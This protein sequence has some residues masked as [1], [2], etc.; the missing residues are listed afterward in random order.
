MPAQAIFYTLLGL[1]LGILVTICIVHYK[2]KKSVSQLEAQAK[3]VLQKAQAEEKKILSEAEQ[4]SKRLLDSIS[5]EEQERKKRLQE[6]EQKQQKREKEIEQKSAA[7]HQ[8][9]REISQ[10]LERIRQETDK[11][12]LKQRE[13]EA[14]LQQISSLSPNEAR[15]LLLKKVEQE[16]E[17]DLAHHLE[18]I[19]QQTKETAA[20]QVKNILAEAMQ[21]YYGESIAESTIT[22]VPLP[23]DEMKGRIIGREGRNINAFEKLSGVDLIVD[24]TPGAVILSGF[25]LIRRYI[26]KLALERLVADG[27]IHPT[28][29]E[30][31]ITKAKEDVAKMIKEF[32]EK[33]VYELGITGL[34]NEIVKLLGR[35]RFR[36]AYGQNIL[37]HSVEVA[38][39]AAAIATEFGANA[40][41]AKRAGLLHDIGKA[42][43]QEIDGDHCEIGQEIAKKYHLSAEIISAIASH[44]GTVPF[45]S[46]EGIIVYIA[47]LLSHQRQGSQRENLEQHIQ[48]MSNLEQTAL[49]FSGVEQAFAIQAG[50]ELRI[51]VNPSI[52]SDTEAYRLA[53]D[54]AK[55]AEKSSG[56]TGEIKV[57][58]VRETRIIEYAR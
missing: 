3:D 29:I 45:T 27:R 26:A 16:H 11:L 22:T 7:L 31:S 9:E 37:K 43:D 55:A 15:E 47:N 24:E 42:L 41:I 14:M 46:I 51:I 56:F 17:E 23:N 30:E 32:G 53:H 39:L 18:K 40:D 13:A 33:V 12:S 34:P 28:K 50:K 48:R 35:L 44:H 19:I 5:R 4:Q 38:K 58:V 25:D 8:N 52:V 6:T 57:N 1:V 10:E 49:T 36:T 21:R 54:L 2:R 20:T